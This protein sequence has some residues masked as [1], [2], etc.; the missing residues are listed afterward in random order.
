[1]AKVELVTPRP[2]LIN[3]YDDH[4]PGVGRRRWALLGV[5]LAYFMVLL[6]MT[7]L[8]VAEP[9]LAASL[10]TSIAG[11]QWVVDGYTV[12]FAALLLSGGAVA[13]TY[14]A[15]RVFR[16]AVMVFGAGSVASALAPSVGV[17]VG[18]RVLLGAAA[19]GV[20]PASM[21]II[22]HLYP[23]PGLRARAIALWA[24]ISGTAVAAGPII[25]GGLVA[26]AG[27]RAIFLVNTPLALL[28]LALT[29]AGVVTCP[30]RRRRIDWPALVSACVVLA[31]LTDAV[32]AAG[33]AF[34]LN[35]AAAGFAT[36]AVAVWFAA[37]ERR[38][39][40]PVLNR[41]LLSRS[42]VNGALAVGAAVTFALNGN[43]FTLALLFQQGRQLSAIGTGLAFLPL[44]L[45]F[46]LN[47]PIVGRLVA[48]FGPR[49]PILTGVVLLTTGDAL[50]AWVTGTH[51]GYLWMAGGLL[52]TGLGVSFALPA[53]VAAMI[54]AAP[55]GSAGAVGG[56]LNAVRQVGATLGVATMGVL[57][58]VDSIDTGTT[59]ALGLS[60]LVCAAAGTWYARATTM[61]PQPSPVDASGQ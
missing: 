18:L 4:P 39:P 15:H 36:L 16:L 29:A 53:L 19:A 17:L 37:R 1:M 25:G 31:L 26:A 55:T 38:S 56:L 8:A 46:T 57:L 45:P 34:W 6:D 41:A 48:R 49:P 54:N 59:Y 42:G 35:A 51:A 40:A 9:D 44:T 5:A 7:V 43:L 22:A 3:K 61:C 11:L 21:A 20:V 10:D 12:V 23:E 13:D 30:R 52:L 14:G 60:A 50:L 28:V 24:A 27:W 47:P 33:H 58:G 32:I 2:A